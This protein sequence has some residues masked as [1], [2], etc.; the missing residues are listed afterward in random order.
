MTPQ[1]TWTTIKVLAWTKDYLCTKGIENARLEAEWLLCAATGLDRVG[2]YLHFDKPL[3]DDEL[4][5]FRAM[6]ARRARREPLQHILGTQ[7]FCG[8]EF[9]VSPDVL[10]PRHDTETLVTE[11]LARQPEARSVLDIG[12]GSGCIAVALAHSLPQAAVTA[13]DISPAALA[14]ARRNAE[15]NGATVEF[16]AGSLLEP[17]AGRTFDLIVSNPPYIPTADIDRLEPEVRDF[18]PR[19]ALDG[20]PDGL[21]VYRTLIPA[22]PAHLN[23]AGWLLVEVGIGQA[24]AVAELFRKANNYDNP[25]TARDPGGIERVVGAQ[26]KDVS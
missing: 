15:H 11:A 6:V 3:N 13:I 24:P 1:E 20:G 8:L 18:D 16:L 19:G 21:D 4:A 14:M 26:R 25:V 23:P 5:S 17:V 10:I 12:T 22:V 2:L 9:Q 7:E